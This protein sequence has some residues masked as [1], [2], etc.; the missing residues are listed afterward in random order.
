MTR[1][2]KLATFTL[3]AASALCVPATAQL[4]GQPQIPE[5]DPARVKKAKQRAIDAEWMWQY[6]PPPEGGRENELIQDPHFQ[7]FL[8]QNLIAPQSFWGP[9]KDGARK[10]LAETAYDFLTIPGK[11]IADRNRYITVTGHVFHFPASRGLLFTDLNDAR[12]LVVFA[13]IDWI[14]DNR[15]T[16]DPAAE[17]TVWLFANR[18][19]AAGDS[20]DHLPT[21]LVHSLVRWMAE[22]PA[23][24]TVLQKI[25]A[26][27]LVDPDG[28]PHQITVPKE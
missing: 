7:P 20:A 11:V 22:P 23:G 3:V 14:R 15:S 6:G 25:S 27:I 8:T 26:A 16:D 19:L 18:P 28:T 24:T 2:L 9:Q 17:Y 21:A 1:P 4:L 13:A 12:P 5:R 10:T